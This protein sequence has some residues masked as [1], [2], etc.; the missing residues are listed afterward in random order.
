M[1]ERPVPGFEPS[2]EALAESRR[3]FDLARQSIEDAIASASLRTPHSAEVTLNLLIAL[4]HG[5]AA[6][7]LANEPRL[8]AGAGRFGSLIPVLVETLR[9]AWSGADQPQSRS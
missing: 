7:H 5:V 2:T 1:F 8:P 6:Q 9:A 4:M 3:M